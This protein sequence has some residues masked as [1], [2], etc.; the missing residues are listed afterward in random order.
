MYTVT[1]NSSLIARNMTHAGAITF[2][3]LAIALGYQ[4]VHV[5]VANRT[6]EVR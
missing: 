3:L 6:M 1:S 4:N 5:H 2:Q